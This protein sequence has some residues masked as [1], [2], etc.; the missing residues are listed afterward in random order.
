MWNQFWF[1]QSKVPGVKS[2]ISK[3]SNSK[4]DLLVEAGDKIYFGDLYLEVRSSARLV[5][6]L[7]YSDLKSL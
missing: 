4:A 2:I 1:H 3:S 7:I 5:L 6:W